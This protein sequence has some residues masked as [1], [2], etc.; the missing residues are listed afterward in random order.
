M[1]GTAE[2]VGLCAKQILDR[3][4]QGVTSSA[5]DRNATG[6]GDLPIRG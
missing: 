5:V 1:K 3:L 2:L 4:G 6:L